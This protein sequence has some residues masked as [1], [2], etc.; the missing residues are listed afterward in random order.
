MVHPKI[1]ICL[2]AH[3]S[4]KYVHSAI[5]SVLAQTFS[6]WEMLISDDA[7]S[8]GTADIAR[9]Y[10]T[11]R[12]IRYVYH[13]E[14]LKQGANWAYAIQNT[15][16][17]YVTTLHAD[18]VWETHAL[19]AFS[20]VFAE[21][22]NLDLAWANWDYYDARLQQKRGT[23][24][25]TE[26]I[27]MR[28][29]EGVKWLV[30]HNHAL[31]SA[32]GFS[33]KASTLAG[34]PDHRYGMVCDRE[35]FLRI[36]SVAQFCRALPLVITRYRQHEASVTH[37]FSTTGK[38][39]KEMILLADNANQTFRF[40]SQ[41]GDWLVQGLQSELGKELFVA[42][43][44]AMLSGR[45]TQAQTWLKKGVQLAG[46]NIVDIEVAKSLCRS[47]RHITRK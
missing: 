46:W 1:S 10:L 21:H 30:R 28:G 2:L 11:D 39:Q 27:Q 19:A 18:D 16:A 12:R 40:C 6:D 34:L 4:E 17:P 3:N 32:T 15:R 14:N 33:R 5:E 36:A 43:V 47:A 22:E 23:A 42:G 35:F 8:D 9:S 37:N 41:Q 24:P 7:S 25:V 20:D 29:C 45:S 26:A 13:E 31:P 44:T 38:L